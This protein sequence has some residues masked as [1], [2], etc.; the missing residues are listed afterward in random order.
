MFPVDR[1]NLSGILRTVET[2]EKDMSALEID[3]DSDEQPNNDV[4]IAFAR[5]FSG[6]VRKGMKLYVLGPKYD[7]RTSN[8]QEII[9]SPHICEVEIDNLFLLMGRDLQAIDEIPAGNIVGEWGE[10]SLFF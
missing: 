8:K 6:T 1:K 5:I 2:L 9:S 7:P 10:S 3:G 4:F